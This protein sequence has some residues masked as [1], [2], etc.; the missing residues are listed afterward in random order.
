MK[1]KHFLKLLAPTA[2]ALGGITLG[3]VSPASAAA[4]LTITPISWNIIGLDSNNVNVGPNTFLV[5]ARVCN[6]GTTAASNVTAN[7]IWDSTNP[8]INLSGPSTLSIPSLPAGSQ[9]L[10]SST[11]NYTPTNC[12]DFYFNG[13][14][15][16][17][18][19]AYNATRRYRITVTDGTTTVSTPTP[20]E[21][22]VE[23]L[24]SQNRNA[25]NSFSVVGNPPA[26]IV[27]RTYEFTFSGKTATGGYE[28]LEHFPNFPNTQFQL[29]SVATTYAEP[30]GAINSTIYAD[31]CGW[32][33]DPTSS[34]YHNNLECSDPTIQD[35]Y[36][37]GKAGGSSITTTYKVKILSQGSA[38]INNLIYDYSG[39][40][41]HYNSDYDSK[42]TFITT[43]NPVP[44]IGVAKA[45]GTVVNNN[46]GT[47]TV[48]FTVTVQNYGEEALKNVQVTEDLLTSFT[49]A[50]N[51]SVSTPAVTVTAPGIDTPVTNL[52][53]AGTAFTGQGGTANTGGVNNLL[54]GG[55]NS[56]LAV[57][58]KA[59]IT[60]NVTFKPGIS[61]STFNNTVIAT[62]TG[63][64]TNTNV[65]DNST[66]GTAPD[67]T[68][69]GTSTNNGDN[70]PTNNTSPTPINFPRLGV[71]KT[72][73]NSVKQANGSYNIT[74]SVK[75][76]N[77]GSESLTGVQ[78]TDALLSTFN[79]ITATNITIVTAP[80]VT[81]VNAGTPTPS[82]TT[83]TAN[84]SFTGKGGA[85]DTNGVNNLLSG[86][87]NVLAKGAEANI[88]FTINVQPGTV[89]GTFNN[90]A[91]GTGTGAVT[92][93]ATND[94]SQDGTDPDNTSGG[95]AANNGDGY[96]GNNSDPTVFIV[97]GSPNLVLVKRITAVDS[98]TYT[99][100]K[101]DPSD[102]NDN[103]GNWPSGTI[104]GE[105]I[106]PDKAKPGS[107][108]EYTIY[109]LST[110]GSN[111]QNASICDLIPANT[112]FA[113]DA[114]ATGKGIRQALGATITDLTNTA[115]TDS[116]Q[117]YS[118][119][120]TPPASCRIGQ[121]LTNGNGTFTPTNVG[122]A[123]V[124]NLGTVSTKASD[125]NK[126]YG[127][128][129]FRAKVN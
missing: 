57:D 28:Q 40:S 87:S 39:S 104:V 122:G 65:A 62:G 86:T 83:L 37:G 75:L 99:T 2:L 73:T 126:Y 25:V 24:I 46:N 1:T 121:T 8:Y 56:I 66:D 94:A 30:T 92:T 38:T 74:Y 123:V 3:S 11:I 61:N 82:A 64:V 124:V 93:A 60:F 29:L 5:G 69:S 91:N 33:N 17:T 108:V 22:Y 100:F 44:R 18:N 109:F 54:T 10:S 77:Y 67:N 47:Y 111:A 117:F 63:N 59:T 9:P 41:Y 125:A 6:V 88:T 7:L 43:R 90:T 120:A 4:Q 51:I 113:L 81:V 68:V 52:A 127:Y 119:T 80:S 85:T 89:T 72:I 98:T 79:P 95:L 115:D 76:K 103:N 70:D 78:V 50:T 13:V 71:A 45:A 114:F 12:F 36:S 55:A 20:S 35:A 21:L 19:L 49:G 106:A 31:A 26:I 27:G 15:T 116:G 58:A 107:T 14:I 34:Y 48:P 23:K 84:T 97:A 128:V 110:G 129:K 101:D 32:T 42:G 102:Q 96:P 16:R 112:T 105:Y 53:S 118:A